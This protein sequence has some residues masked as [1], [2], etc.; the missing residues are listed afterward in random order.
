MYTVDV[1]SLSS[2]DQVLF[3]ILL[4][5]RTTWFH[6]Q[7][8]CWGL[9]C[10]GLHKMSKQLCLLQQVLKPVGPIRLL[11]TWGGETVLKKRG[12]AHVLTK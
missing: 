8:R 9:L 2:G 11:W 7:W 3:L 6:F 12:A 10:S 4:D 1:H 5:P